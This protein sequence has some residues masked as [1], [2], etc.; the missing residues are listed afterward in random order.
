MG[1]TAIRF[2]AVVLTGL[3]LVAPGAHFLELANK[4]SLPEEQYFVVQAIYRGWWIVGIA[5]P[6]ALVTNL[7]LAIMIRQDRLGFRLAIV[8]AALIG[9]NLTIFSFWTYPANAFTENWSVCPDNWE[10]LRRQWEYSHAINAIVTF[11]AFCFATIAALRVPS[12]RVE[13]T[14]APELR[15]PELQ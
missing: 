4:I 15:V 6:L 9:L 12:R 1:L 7:V 2:L 8:G 3:A 14:R 13:H 11:F 5:L 10:I